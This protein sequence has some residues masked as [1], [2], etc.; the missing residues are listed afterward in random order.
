MCQDK[1]TVCAHNDDLRVAGFF[2]GE[3]LAV[4]TITGP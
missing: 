3:G 1:L 4:N 2:T